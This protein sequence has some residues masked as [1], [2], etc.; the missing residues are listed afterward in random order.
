MTTTPLKCSGCGQAPTFATDLTDTGVVGWRLF[1]LCWTCATGKGS[2]PAWRNAYAELR[3]LQ[4][5]L[6]DV[7]QGG[8]FKPGRNVFAGY[9][10]SLDFKRETRGVLVR[11]A[12]GDF[13][14]EL[15][16]SSGL[17]L[18]RIDTKWWNI[19]PARS[20]KAV[21]CG[22]NWRWHAERGAKKLVALLNWRLSEEELFE[23]VRRSSAVS[24][25][26]AL[27]TVRTVRPKYARLGSELAY[28]N[29]KRRKKNPVT[30]VKGLT[31]AQ[32]EEQQA[33]QLVNKGDGHE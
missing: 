13:P 21:I 5:E 19:V 29:R 15:P 32:W 28:R 17:A 7:D 22:A 26:L 24:L 12:R 10:A 23:Q 8:A 33:R 1:A 9:A 25:T 20:G 2:D 11:D 30:M 6:V 4:L 27:I 31:R 16:Y 14:E 3:G 18:R